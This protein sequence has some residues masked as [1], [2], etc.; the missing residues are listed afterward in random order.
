MFSYEI[1]PTSNPKK[2][3]NIHSGNNWARKRN[4]I[5]TKKQNKISSFADD[6][7]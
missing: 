4:K 7:L 5:Y 1:K 6:Y 2:K 3:A